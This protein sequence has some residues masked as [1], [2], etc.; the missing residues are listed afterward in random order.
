MRDAC[1]PTFDD[2]AVAS[3]F[4]WQAIEDARKNDLPICGTAE[5]LEQIHER[6]RSMKDGYGLLR[7]Q[8]SR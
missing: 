7:K 8:T 3:A 5:E 6:R 4:A 1:L 2:A